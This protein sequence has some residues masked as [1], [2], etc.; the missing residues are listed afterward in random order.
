MLRISAA[1]KMGKE[2]RKKREEKKS[3]A[4]ALGR[5]YAEEGE[6]ESSVQDTWYQYKSKMNLTVIKSDS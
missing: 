1:A 4:D 2:K 5:G 6:K 3:D